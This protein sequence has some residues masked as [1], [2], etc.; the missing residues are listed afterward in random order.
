M[1]VTAIVKSAAVFGAD[2]NVDPVHHT[3]GQVWSSRGA[4]KHLNV[5]VRRTAVVSLAYDLA[6]WWNMALSF[7]ILSGREA[8]ELPLGNIVRL[9]ILGR[10]PVVINQYARWPSTSSHSLHRIGPL[11]KCNV[12]SNAHH[13]AYR[14]VIVHLHDGVKPWLNDALPV[15]TSNRRH[16]MVVR[17]ENLPP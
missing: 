13:D 9:N 4:W 17:H 1:H 6:L 2:V 15:E 14:P 12:D 8:G 5:A 7:C 3:N 11:P 16:I 10:A